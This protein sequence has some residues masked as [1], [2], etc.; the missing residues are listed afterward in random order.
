MSILWPTDFWQRESCR[1]VPS[2]IPSGS[3]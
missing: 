3:H 2:C 1:G